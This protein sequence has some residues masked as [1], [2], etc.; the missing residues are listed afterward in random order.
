M[1]FRIKD[2]GARCS[3]ASGCLFSQSLSVDRSGKQACVCMCNSHVHPPVSPFLSVSIENHGFTPIPLILVQHHRAHP[4]LAPLHICTFVRQRGED[5]FRY[6]LCFPNCSV[7]LYMASLWPCWPAI[8]LTAPSHARA[9]GCLPQGRK[10]PD[11]AGSS[12]SL[13]SPSL[14]LE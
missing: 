13:L 12:V 2:Q 9:L 10:T 8:P 4:S 1:I 11:L 6:S 14:F 5:C 7:P 3:L